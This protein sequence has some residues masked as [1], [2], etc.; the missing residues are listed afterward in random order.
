MLSLSNWGCELCVDELKVEFKSPEGRY[1]AAVFERNCGATTEYITHLNLRE[2]RGKFKADSNGVISEGEV[3]TIEG[4]AEIKVTWLSETLILIE[5][6]GVEQ[7]SAKEK[8]WKDVTI[9]Y[10]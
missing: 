6:S 4:L 5:M 8:S 1:V 7:V 3:C 2:A 10:K 9:S